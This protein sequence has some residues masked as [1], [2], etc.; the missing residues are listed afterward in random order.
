VSWSRLRKGFKTYRGE[1]FENFR[2]MESDSMFLR[3]REV[4]RLR[5]RDLKVFFENHRRFFWPG[6]HFTKKYHMIK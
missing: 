3:G 5:T 4:S 2:C 6:V 1:K